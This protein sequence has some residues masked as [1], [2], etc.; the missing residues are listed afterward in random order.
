MTG[1]GLTV[2]QKAVI[3]HNMLALQTLYTNISFQQLALV[4]DMDQRLVEKV[5]E[6]NLFNECLYVCMYVCLYVC[7]IRL[8]CMYDFLLDNIYIYSDLSYYL[9]CLFV[10]YV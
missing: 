1:D 8:L 6:L 4:L 5:S 3:E 7:Y 10:C 2:L 9:F